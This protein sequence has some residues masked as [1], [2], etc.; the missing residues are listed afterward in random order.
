MINWK[1]PLLA[2]CLIT[3]T[4][5]SLLAP[6]AK[7]ALLGGAQKGIE[8]D[9][10]AGKA[11]GTGDDS[12]AQNANTAV[13]VDA[14]S[15]EVIEGDVGQVINENGIPPYALF[16]LV[17]LAGW[18]IPSPSEM[19]NGLVRLVTALS[20]RRAGEARSGGRVSFAR[21]SDNT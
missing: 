20:G 9:A 17:L 13:S 10:N 6:L 11:E 14:G 16:L 5:C 7:E 2:L 8:V 3:Q 21:R 1:I 12:V 15:K 4:G 18:A 19:G